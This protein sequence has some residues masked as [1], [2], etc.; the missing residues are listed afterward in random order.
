MMSLKK[1]KKGVDNIGLWF[2]HITKETKG[3]RQAMNECKT[4][5]Q[6]TNLISLIAAISAAVVLVIALFIAR[7]FVAI[8]I[9]LALICA[10][11]IMLREIKEKLV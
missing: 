11:W 8:L 7:I 1:F 3:E 10:A 6:N 4:S 2:Y 5:F 9:D